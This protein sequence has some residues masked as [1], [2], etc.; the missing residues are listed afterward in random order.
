MALLVNK[1]N[2]EVKVIIPNMREFRAFYSASEGSIMFFKRDWQEMKT[3]E[4]WKPSKEQMEALKCAIAD[5]ARFS[6]RGGRQVELE[7]EPYYS[8]LH[9]LYCNLEKLM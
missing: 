3:E 6:K 7:N 2:P 8:A 9:S 1:L 5:V 4:S